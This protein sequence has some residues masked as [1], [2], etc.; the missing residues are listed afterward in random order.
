MAKTT[1]KLKRMLLP[2]DRLLSVQN[3]ND[4]RGIRMEAK[5]MFDL[6][7]NLLQHWDRDET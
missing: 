1:M 3:G 6:K 4:D 5:Q 2:L 7:L